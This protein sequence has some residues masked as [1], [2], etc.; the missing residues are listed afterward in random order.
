M[1][2]LFSLIL[3]TKVRHGSITADGISCTEK[4]YDN[5]VSLGLKVT[6]LLHEN[7]EE[8][9]LGKSEKDP[10]FAKGSSSSGRRHPPAGW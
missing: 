9:P 10:Y 5:A 4:E 7:P 8:I 2:A 3:G 6:A 1:A